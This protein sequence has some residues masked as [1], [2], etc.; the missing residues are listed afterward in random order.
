MKVTDVLSAWHAPGKGRKPQPENKVPFQ[1]ILPM[2]LKD[3]VS[4]K[5]DKNKGTNL[6]I[7]IIL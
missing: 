2:K 6:L 7:N 4:G 1:E 3:R 5:F